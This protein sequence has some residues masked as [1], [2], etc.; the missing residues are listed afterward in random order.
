MAVS[1]LVAT[2]TMVFPVAGG[3][4]DTHT[5]SSPPSFTLADMEG[6]NVA[7]S[8]NH[9]IKYSLGIMIYGMAYL[10]LDTG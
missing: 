10:L 7:R 1:A 2:V 4:N 3:S 5:W 8:V 9:K 6:S